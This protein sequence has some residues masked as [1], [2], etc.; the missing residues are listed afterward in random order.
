M[1]H[2]VTLHR[3][4]QKKRFCFVKWV[5]GFLIF[6]QI[7]CIGICVYLSNKSLHIVQ[8]DFL[9]LS[10]VVILCHVTGGLSCALYIQHP[11]VVTIKDCSDSQMSSEGQSHNLLRLTG[12][13]NQ[14]HSSYCEDSLS[15]TI[16]IPIFYS[17]EAT[18]SNNF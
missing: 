14:I 6:S 12:I 17:T 7:T 3:N 11:S 8:T 13:E 2:E 5:L 15:P 18:T 4:L 10:T 1:A 9:N 16:H